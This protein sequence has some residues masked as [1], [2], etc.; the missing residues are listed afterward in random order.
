MTSNKPSE[1]NSKMKEMNVMQGREN[2]GLPFTLDTS[3]VYKIYTGETLLEN[4]F[5][6]SV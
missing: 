3:K 2:F 6:K 4:I 1:G 5:G